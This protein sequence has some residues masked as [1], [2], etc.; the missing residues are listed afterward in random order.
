MY[1][2]L[3]NVKYSFVWKP[4]GSKVLC[5]P[6]FILYRRRY[7]DIIEMDIKEIGQGAWTGLVCPRIETGRGF[8]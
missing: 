6:T 5:K 2:T 7:E 4:D 3:R 1:Y 8:W